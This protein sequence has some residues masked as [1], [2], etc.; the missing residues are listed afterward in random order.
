MNPINFPF[1]GNSAVMAI[2]ILVHVF[3]AFVAVG[4]LTIAFITEWIG[5]KKGSEFHDRFAK[6]YVKFISDMMKVGGVLGT[7]I[8]VLL[9]GLF[10]EFTKKLFNVF[11]WPF[12]VEGVTFLVLMSAS[13]SYRGTWEKI[14]S[15]ASHLFLGFL[16]VFAAVAGAI[17]INAIHAFMLT[18]GDYFNK[19]SVFSALF[20]PTMP[21]SSF[22]LLIPCIANAAAFAFIYYFFKSR[23]S[24][25]PYYK[26]ALQ[27]CG[28]IF[29]FVILL[30]PLSGL[31]FLFKVKAVNDTIFTNIVNGP[32]SKFF[33]PMVSLGVVAVVS[34]LIYIAGKKKLSSLLLVG[35]L[36]ALTAFSFGGYTRE[37]ARKPYL[38]YGHM[39]MSEAFAGQIQ[40]AAV[41]A[42]VKAALQNKGCLS[43]HKFKGDGGTFGPALDEHLL[44]HSKDELKKILR[45]PP[46][47]MP[48]F[49]GSDEELDEFLD[50]VRG[51][52]KL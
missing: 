42:D 23:K 37:R 8:V 24:E 7:I 3:F 16:A 5:Y 51:K 48:P 22:H 49:V 43:C 27:Y 28:K 39:L 47:T 20:N 30:Q 32:I 14:T 19:P 6:G 33:Y 15:K 52:E 25:E 50:I 31:S 41:K 1:L 26:W 17:I 10:P 34:S 18:P 29:A 36:S 38:I 44:H 46:S 13:V 4:G 9:I 11:F 35:S 45:K 12:V 2:F 21:E 40:T